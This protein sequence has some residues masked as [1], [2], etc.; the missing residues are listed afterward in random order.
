MA[1]QTLLGASH[2]EG[3]ELGRCWNGEEK[4]LK[5]M[6]ERQRF[7]EFQVCILLFCY[8]F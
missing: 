8:I 1:L 4:V 5:S 2:K 6:G 3:Q 7:E